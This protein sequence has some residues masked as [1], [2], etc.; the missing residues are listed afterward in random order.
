MPGIGFLFSALGFVR[1]AAQALFGMIR[2]YPLQAA[3]IASLALSA[4][5]WHGRS[6]ARDE[7]DAARHQVVLWKDANAK[8]T[9]WAKAEAARKDRLASDITK[10]ANDARSIIQTAGVRAGDD[11][12]RANQ[13][14]RFTPAK[15]G[16]QRPD[17]PRPVPVAGQ[18]ESEGENA[19]LVGVTTASFNACT[20][21]SLDL[22]NAQSW[23]AD[24]VA[25]GLAK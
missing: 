23:A 14:V 1:R 17:L 3:L 4:W 24:M 25:K 21:N 20:V 9:L 12:R 8:A 13:C 18:P 22:A 16:G 15:G 6:T 11:Y 5:F 10:G 2:H 7:R 19:E